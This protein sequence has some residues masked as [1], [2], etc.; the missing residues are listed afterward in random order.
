MAANTFVNSLM[1]WLMKRRIPK[2]ENYRD[3]PIECQHEILREHLD[4]CAKTQI[5]K[6][7]GFDKIKTY[8]DFCKAV[9]LFFY[10]EFEPYID[11]ARNGEG[12]LIWP[13]RIQ[14]FAKSS[15][16]T[17]DKSKYIPVTKASL[18]DCHFKAGKDMFS[19]YCNNHPDSQIFGL[20]NLRLGGSSQILEEAYT[21]YGDLSAIMIENLPIWTDIMNAPNR[22]ISL[23]PDWEKKLPA[24]MAD[25]KDKSIGSLTGVPSWML[26]LLQK[27]K[28]DAKFD[29]IDDLWPDLE[30]FFHGGVSFTP[31][32]EVYKSL[33]SKPIRFYEIYNASEGFFAIQDQPNSKDLLLLTEH[34]VFYEFIPMVDFHKKNPTTIPLEKVKTDISYAMVISTNGG[35]WRY[36][37]GD[38]IRFTSTFP[39]RIKVTGRTKLFI[40][41]FGEELV[42]ENAE[43]ALDI[44]C[45]KNECSIIDYTAAPIFME[46][47]SSG[48]HEWLIEFKNHPKNIKNFSQD[49]DEALKNLNS[50]YEAKRY[51]NMTLA[52]PKICIA[53]ENLFHN[54]LKQKGKLGGQN[55][56]PRLSNDRKLIDLL[57]GMNENEPKNK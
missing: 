8:E 56:V 35:L 29:Y 3:H 5:G 36:I 27:L 44:A 31:Y 42:I 4:L 50:D 40:N 49:L 22:K 48:G 26:A 7:Y 51:K 10:E 24:I 52:E 41:A 57:L 20:T 37:I 17:N 32:E 46:K 45:K 13:E 30:V 28:T 2:I 19:I 54:W 39:F 16:T 23:I 18:D 47:E 38:T 6:K 9:P 12:N 55:K 15:G 33:F 21:I 25:V 11:R 43:K 1:N 14:Y 53:K 34:G